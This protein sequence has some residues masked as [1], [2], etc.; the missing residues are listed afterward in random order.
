G[1]T[2]SSLSVTRGQF[3]HAKGDQSHLDVG[4]SNADVVFLPATIDSVKLD[5]CY[6]SPGEHMEFEYTYPVYKANNYE[7]DCVTESSLSVACRQLHGEG[8][9]SHVDVGQS[10]A[11]AVILPATVDGAKLDLRCTSLG[12]HMEFEYT[13]PVY[14]ANNYESEVCTES[15]LNVTCGELHVEGGQS[16]AGVV[17]LPEKMDTSAGEHMEFEYTS[18]VEV[19]L[20]LNKSKIYYLDYSTVVYV[21]PRNESSF[22]IERF[23]DGAVVNGSSSELIYI[24]FDSTAGVGSEPSVTN[25]ISFSINDVDMLEND[26][27]N[28]KHLLC[29]SGAPIQKKSRSCIAGCNI[30]KQTLFSLPCI[31]V[32]GVFDI[33][34][35]QRC[36][37]WVQNIGV[38]HLL[39][40]DSSSLYGEY[41]VCADHF[42]DDQFYNY[43]KRK[44]LPSAVPTIFNETKISDAAMKKFPVLNS[45]EAMFDGNSVN[46]ELFDSYQKNF[47]RIMNDLEWRTCCTCKESFYTQRGS[48]QRCKHSKPVCKNLSAENFMDPGEVPTQLRDLSYVEEQLIAKIHPLISVYKVKGGQFCYK[49]N[50]INFP[51]DVN[52]I[53]TQLPWRINDLSSIITIRTTSEQ[54]KHVD[55]NVRSAKVR[56]ALKYLKNN[57]KKYFN[58]E[59]SEDNLA[60]LPINGNVFDQMKSIEATPDNTSEEF[61]METEEED[62]DMCESGLILTGQPSIQ[63]RVQNILNWPSIGKKAISEFD[64]EKYDI[65]EA[66]PTLFPQGECCLSDSRRSKPVSSI[67][68]FQHLM[69]FHDKR[70]GRHPRFRYFALNSIMRWWAIRDGG[71]FVQK[72]PEITNMTMNE[73]KKKIKDNPSWLNKIMGQSGKLRG[74]RAFWY[75]RGRELISMVEQIGLPTVFFTLSA[76]DYHWPQ[77]F[78]FIAPDEDYSLLTEKRRRELVQ[79]NPMLVDMFFTERVDTYIKEVLKKKYEVQDI[80]FRYE[81]QHR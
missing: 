54:N 27:T 43:Q 33:D 20:G 53:A 77:L 44:L 22:N 76:A 19:C 46:S 73:L 24:N 39:D 15:S 21:D 32:D 40:V 79:E 6:T 68:Y 70:F 41:F 5:L 11:D 36:L 78:K 42:S 66:F 9:Q 2:E 1:V 4:Q 60:A 74:T 64:V 49:G 52:E 25:H 8:D 67:N 37:K 62:I 65:T 72:N 18:C 50:V 10:A 48:S 59:I 29:E 38:L 45:S 51:Q 14:K 26:F 56:D 81:Y 17:I 31:K 80:W 34:K 55:F 61:G 30:E 63:D 3:M 12:E 57:H 28:G 23:D 69:R 35:V 7:S 47:E 16:N 75:A 13:Y 71:V 58:I